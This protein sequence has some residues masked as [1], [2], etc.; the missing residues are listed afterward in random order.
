MKLWANPYLPVVPYY[1]IGILIPT[2]LGTLGGEASVAYG[3]NNLN[4]IVGQSDTDLSSSANGVS[5]H[6][7]LWENGSMIDIGTL[8]GNQSG[9]QSA[10][11]ARQVVGFAYNAEGHERAFLLGKRYDDQSG[12]T[13]WR[14]RHFLCHRC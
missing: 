1:G 2:D 5:P 13:Q 12:K 11:E 8:G 9:A 3:L 7:F 4:Q 6:A 10:N 14:P